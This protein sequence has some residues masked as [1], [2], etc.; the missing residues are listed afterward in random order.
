M[1]FPRQEYWSVLP[2]PPP[3]VLPDPGI[4]PESPALQA[5]SLLL[6]YQGSASFKLFLILKQLCSGILTVVVTEIE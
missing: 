6:N 1:G 2:C 5:D 3:G 4:K